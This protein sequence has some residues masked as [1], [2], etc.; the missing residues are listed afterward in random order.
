MHTAY[1]PWVEDREGLEVYLAPSEASVFWMSVSRF[2]TYPCEFLVGNAGH[3]KYFF[4]QF[5]EMQILAL[6]PVLRPG[7]SPAESLAL[8]LLSPTHS[9]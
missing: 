6:I 5:S 1:R 2:K 9:S 8:P 7:F 4:Y 3:A